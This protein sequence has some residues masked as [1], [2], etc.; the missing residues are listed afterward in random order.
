MLGKCDDSIVPSSLKFFT[1]SFGN[2]SGK[3]PSVLP[4]KIH[5]RTVHVT[6]ATCLDTSQTNTRSTRKTHKARQTYNLSLCKQGVTGSSIPFTTISGHWRENLQPHCCVPISFA[7]LPSIPSYIPLPFVLV[8]NVPYCPLE[9][10]SFPRF[11]SVCH[12]I[13]TTSRHMFVAC[14]RIVTKKLLHRKCTTTRKGQ[15]HVHNNETCAKIAQQ[16]KS[17]KSNNN[18]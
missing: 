2:C 13:C 12:W 5:G 14:C 4:P 3:Y 7:P 18:H 8:D 16:T 10:N 11:P 6:I 1:H 15:Q 17:T 9:K